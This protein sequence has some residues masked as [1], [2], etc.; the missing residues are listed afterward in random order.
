MVHRNHRQES[1]DDA[2][3]PRGRDAGA[4]D[5][6]PG[7]P[8]RR[9]A[10]EDRP[11]RRL[12]GGA[13]RLR[14]RASRTRRTS[15][16]P[17]T[18]RRPTCRRR[19]C[20]ARWR[21]PRARRRRSPATRCSSSIFNQGERVDVDRH[22]Q[23]PRLP[24][25]RQAPPL[26]AAATRR[27]ARCST[28]RPARSAPRR[29]R[30]ASCRACA[31]TATWAWTASPSRNLKVLKIDA[32]NNL[33]LVQGRRARRQRRLRGDPQGRGRQA[34]AAAAAAREAEEGQEVAVPDEWNCHDC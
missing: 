1:R 14:R 21:S 2:A 10:G 18:S 23:G 30:R 28:A 13:A 34:R 4:G 29:I 9:R 7:R 33:L 26:R 20:A 16:R 24:G 17:A 25:R 27:T 8:L 3:V 32:E 5:R 15:R 6:A 12:R 31:R 22:Q 11:D 19:A